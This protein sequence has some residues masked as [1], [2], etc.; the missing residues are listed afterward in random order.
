MDKFEKVAI[1]SYPLKPKMW[2]IFVDNTYVIWPYK[3]ENLEGFFNLLNNQLENIKFTME[4]EENKNIAFLDLLI[5]K[6]NN[7]ALGHQIYRK[8]THMDRYL[9]AR[10]HHRPA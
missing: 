3:K 5:S 9:H 6:K 4:L 7:G 8:K 2:R 1:D 10:S